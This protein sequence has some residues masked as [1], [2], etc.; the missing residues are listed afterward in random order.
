MQAGIVGEARA[1]EEFS[2]GYSLLKKSLQAQGSLTNSQFEILT[3]EILVLCAET[4]IKNGK[5][6]VAHDCSELF[7]L[8]D[9]PQDQFFCR[10]LFIRAQVQAFNSGSATGQDAV[11]RLEV[12]IG[13]IL[14]SIEI[15]LSPSKFPRYNF[16]IYNASVHYWNVT[17]RMMRA[18]ACQYLCDS[19]Q[20]VV[21]AL[22]KSEERSKS[23]LCRYQL[24]L[25]QCFDDKGDSKRAAQCALAAHDIVQKL[26]EET[27]KIESAAL[28]RQVRDFGIYMGRVKDGD[29][30]KLS[31]SVLASWKSAGIVS[32]VCANIE[33]IVQQ[34]KSGAIA[35]PAKIQSALEDALSQL[36]DK[37]NATS[38][39][40][41]DDAPTVRGSGLSSSELDC[42]A[43][44]SFEA[45]RHKLMSVADK[46][47]AAIDRVKQRPPTADVVVGYAKALFVVET[48]GQS[49]APQHCAHIVK[50]VPPQLPQTK[51]RA[52]GLARRLEAIKMLERA[53]LTCQRLRKPDL[54][55]A[56]YRFDARP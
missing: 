43:Q 45:V 42:L 8:R 7:F 39:S 30:G 16:I 3:P 1:K 28:Q 48:F 52:L 17:R 31:N 40:Q 25:A 32:E 21:S 27:P 22:E 47:L 36:L 46:A 53:L 4:A 26:P 56:R 20:V 35:E 15:A 49:Y 55:Q 6:D 14:H 10:A 54:L 12:S 50:A 23:W 2:K 9:P 38:Q 29:C 19:M 33:S 41:D 24:R 44:I 18:G 37:K 11:N 51:Y 5:F 13:H 34:C